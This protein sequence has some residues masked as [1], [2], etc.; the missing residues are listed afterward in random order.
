MH[1]S[2]EI[3][4]FDTELRVTN[5]SI[6]DKFTVSNL[7]TLDTLDTIDTIEDVGDTGRSLSSNDEARDGHGVLG[8]PTFIDLLIT[9]SDRVVNSDA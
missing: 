2:K 4:T 1:Q 3:K 8:T 5:C 6:R 9:I 7:D